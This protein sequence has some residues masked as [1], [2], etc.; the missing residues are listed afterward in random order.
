MYKKNRHLQFH[1]IFMFL[2]WGFFSS[3]DFEWANTEHFNNNKQ[4]L[5]NAVR[6]C[7]SVYE[8]GYFHHMNGEGS[9]S[10][11]GDRIVHVVS[12]L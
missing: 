1:Q 12:R 9:I 10:Q 5:T 8:N 7:M 3:Y 4:L 11:G 6:V 2:V